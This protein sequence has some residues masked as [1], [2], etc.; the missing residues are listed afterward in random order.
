MLHYQIRVRLRRIVRLLQ[1]CLWFYSRY[2]DIC[3]HREPD[4][5][6]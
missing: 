5:C 6:D 2:V 3:V 1:S 4:E